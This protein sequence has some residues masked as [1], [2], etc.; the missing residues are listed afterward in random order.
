MSDI[1]DITWFKESIEPSLNEY[2]IEYKFF[3]EGDFGSLNQ[4]EFNSNKKGGNI[5]F[6]ELGWVGIFIWD[7]INEKEIMNILLKPEQHKEIEVSLK[8]L[9]KLLT[10]Q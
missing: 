3:E 4:V 7:Y 2:K 5:D 6:W 10:Q 9:Q 1:K 8:K